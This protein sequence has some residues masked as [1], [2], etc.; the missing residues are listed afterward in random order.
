MSEL[1]QILYLKVTR[2]GNDNQ[3]VSML[4][5]TDILVCLHSTLHD[6][7]IYNQWRNSVER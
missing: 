3:A 1:R 5:V 7:F 2:Y 6:V 4:H